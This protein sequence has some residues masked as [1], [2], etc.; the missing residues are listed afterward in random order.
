[1]FVVCCSLVVLPCLLIVVRCVS[2]VGC[3]LLGVVGI[4]CLALCF[5][6]CWLLVLSCWLLVV[7]L[8]VGGRHVQV[9]G[10]CGVL[11]VVL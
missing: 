4:C 1:M 9:V 5:V 11:L 3:W 2:C 6:F 8:A 10:C 7:R